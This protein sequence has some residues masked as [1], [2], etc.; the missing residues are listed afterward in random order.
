MERLTSREPRISG[1][2]GVCCTH[3]KGPECQTL[4]GCCTE[5]CP[6]EEAAWER[7]AAYED[8]GMAPEE[9]TAL[10]APN[11]TFPPEGP[12]GLTR[13]YIVRKADTGEE[14]GDCFVLRPKKDWAA[15]Y[16][17]R[18]YADITNNTKLHDDL[19]KWVGE[20]PISSYD[21]E[22]ARIDQSK[23]QM[24]PCPRCGG[25]GLIYY[26]GPK[27]YY[28]ECEDC[29][30]EL[31][32]IYFSA[33]EAAAAWNHRAEQPNAP[34]TL[35][36]LREMDGEPVFIKCLFNDE[37]S[38]YVVVDKRRDSAGIFTRLFYASFDYYGDEWLAYR[39]KPEGNV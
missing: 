5:G 8:T 16:A 25:K 20:F 36:E 26:E 23:L 10:I 12:M 22:S 31:H 24:K 33:E 11:D 3:F 7:L 2:P 17:V 13:K 35:S 9:I 34:L 15:R 6:W 37:L 39:R 38:S 19:L 14:V 4:G 30:L 21:P 27:C 1:F 28:A 32:E 29:P 18:A